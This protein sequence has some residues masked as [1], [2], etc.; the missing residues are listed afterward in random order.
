MILIKD[1]RM[2]VNFFSFFMHYYT[3]FLE[4][5]HAIMQMMEP[6]LAGC[7]SQNTGSELWLEL[8]VTIPLKPKVNLINWHLNPYLEN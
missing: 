5:K 6:R 1:M 7:A 3:F 8:G 2:R 4:N